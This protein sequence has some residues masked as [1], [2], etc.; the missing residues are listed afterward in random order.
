[1][2][3]DKLSLSMSCVSLVFT[4]RCGV[5]GKVTGVTISTAEGVRT[6]EWRKRCRAA[7][8]LL[9]AD[10]RICIGTFKTQQYRSLCSPQSKS[11]KRWEIQTFVFGNFTSFALLDK[12]LAST[13]P[14]P[15]IHLKMEH[16]NSSS[17]LNV[18]WFNFFFWLELILLPT[19][20][21]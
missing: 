20:W 14:A 15:G 11:F 7:A 1:M 21:L 9:S 8:G 2:D 3:G 6:E 19:Q 10:L 12:G 17:S 16:C 18:M 13:G 5:S 4:W